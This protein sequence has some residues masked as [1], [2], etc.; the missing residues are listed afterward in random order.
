MET[1][2]QTQKVHEKEMSDEEARRIALD[3]REKEIEM[4]M[5]NLEEKE[6]EAEA[7]KAKKEAEKA[8]KD[9]ETTARRDRR[10][11][12]KE[13]LKK[14]QQRLEKA[15]EGSDESEASVEE[16]VPTTPESVPR[17]EKKGEKK[18]KVRKVSHSESSD[19]GCTKFT[20]QARTKVPTL[21]KGM[22]YAKYKINVDMWK[23]AMK[24]Y[25]SEK[26]MGM[27]LLQSLPNEDNRGGI[28]EQA[29]KKLGIDKLLCRDGVKNLLQFLDK[30]LLKT[31][32]VRCIELKEVCH[33]LF[34]YQLDFS[35]LL[36]SLLLYAS[37]IVFVH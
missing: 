4:R 26:N 31:N 13:D 24:G 1:W 2:G 16:T 7:E 5:K 28:K 3:E 22:T 12:R 10:K 27:T 36:P 25:M 29:W 33:A 34:A 21:E 11:E 37:S 18:K 32:F 20:L 17:K 15:L 30:K 19:E 35:Q 8:K 6:K 14:L 23:S 9:E